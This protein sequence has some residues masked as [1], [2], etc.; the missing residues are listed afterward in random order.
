MNAKVVVTVCDRY[1]WSLLPFAYLFN[2]YWGED[3]NV[4]IAGYS[5]PDFGL[6]PNFKFYS[7]ADKEYPKEK[8]VDGIV[9]FMNS[10]GEEQ[11]VLMLEDYWLCRRVDR[12]GIEVLSN[13]MSLNKDII[14]LDLTADRLYA[15]GMKDYGYYNRY[16]LVEASKSPY[17]MSL[18]AGIWNKNLFLEILNKLPQDKH[19][20]W[21]VELEGTTI[22]NNFPYRVLGTRQFLVRYANGINNTTGINRNLS[23]M[24]HEDGDIIL[25]MIGD[26]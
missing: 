19:S 25:K 5:K 8:W 18:Q 11:F 3:Q 14:R 1:L 13:Y 6:P 12:Q 7:I 22:L 9:K 4:I 26:R 21:D 15:G 20:A 23:E 17:Q 24:S 2:K 16:D 10:F